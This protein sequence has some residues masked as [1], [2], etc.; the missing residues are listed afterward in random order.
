MQI[1]RLEEHNES[2]LQW[3]RRVKEEQNRNIPQLSFSKKK[4]TQK[5][6]RKIKPYSWNILLIYFTQSQTTALN[7]N[8]THSFIK[9]RSNSIRSPSNNFSS[10]YIYIYIYIWY[11]FYTLWPWTYRVYWKEYA[12]LHKNVFQFNLNL[13]NQRTPLHIPSRKG[14]FFVICQDKP[15]SM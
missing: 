3:K 9:E 6:H 2:P 14:A 15:T 12:V 11:W 1:R 10:P 7:E 4:N 8:K 13:Y 5:T